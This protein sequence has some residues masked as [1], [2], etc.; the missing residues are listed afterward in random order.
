MI[1]V[2][3]VLRVHVDFPT[4][5]DALI[6]LPELPGSLGLKLARAF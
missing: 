3:R 5:C 4:T 1:S 6:R 2:A